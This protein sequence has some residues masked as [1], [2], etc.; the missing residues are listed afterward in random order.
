M[1]PALA[2]CLDALAPMELIQ[3]A[4]ERQWQQ[5]QQ[6]TTYPWGE[7]RPFGTL[8][9]D[10]VTL[11]SE[12]DRLTGSQKQQVIDAVFE[13]TLTP[14]EEQAIFGM[15]LRGPYTIYASDE[16]MIYQASTC[17]D[18]TML[19]E[20]ARYAYHYNFAGLS[21]TQSEREV[22]SRNAGRPAW[23]NVQFP[24]SV[25]QERETRLQFWNAIGYKQ[26]ANDWWIAWVPEQGHFEVNVPVG[27]SQQSLQ[28]FWQVAPQQYRYVVVAA[29]GTFVQEHTF[30]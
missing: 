30:R 12:F 13:Y 24:I 4:M 16:R 10:R 7:A 14:E 28:R 3:P 20:K 17:H 19:T 11:T 22:D 26:A 23:R 2:W 8:V 9:G 1:S 15:G 25:A 29:D 21:A 5:L 27:Y 6:Q 18:L